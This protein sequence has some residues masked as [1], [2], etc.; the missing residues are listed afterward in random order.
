MV[1]LIV[2]SDLALISP[3]MAVLNEAK[4]LHTVDPAYGVANAGFVNY[5][6]ST[7]QRVMVPK[8][9][10]AAARDLVQ[11]AMLSTPDDSSETDL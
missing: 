6:I 11:Q 1:E 2:T 9:H 4:I 5:S 7:Y 8:D 10:L 3:I